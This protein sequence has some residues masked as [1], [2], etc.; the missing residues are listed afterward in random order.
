MTDAPTGPAHE[1][2]PS[3][4][5]LIALLATDLTGPDRTRVDAHLD[6]C[7]RCVETLTVV[8]CRLSLA[9]EVARP[10]PPT[11][12]RQVLDRTVAPVRQSESVAPRAAAA[13]GAALWERITGWLRLPV[14]VP[15]GV[16]AAAVFIVGHTV[17]LGPDA[18]RERARSIQL[19]QTV[20]VTA[21]NA[22][23]RRQPT[24]RGE[25]V[26]TLRR[27]AVVTVTGEDREWYQI[28]LPD[29]TGGWVERSVFE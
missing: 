2:C 29:G 27:G 19:Q 18:P 6:R 9:A 21:S 8:Q 26:A 24:T 20:R 25:A 14:L 13:W 7:D 16:A 15:L 28:A 10:V 5:L 3:D 4:E 11:L 1:S 23:V 12:A 22:V 17:L